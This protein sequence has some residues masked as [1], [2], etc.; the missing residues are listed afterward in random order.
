MFSF[1]AVQ[2]L[3]VLSL[4]VFTKLLTPAD[5]GVY[6][7]FNNTVRVFAIVFSLN[8]FSGYYR[9]Y[10]E[11]DISNKAL[12]QYLLRISF[13]SFLIGTFVFWYFYSTI[14]NAINLPIKLAF[15]LIISIFS[16]IVISFFTNYNNA[17]QKSKRA[18]IWQFIIQ[19]L[20]VVGSL[21]FVIY[22]SKNYEGRIIGENSMLFLITIVIAIVYF[23]KYFG[24][25][26]KLPNKNEIIRYSLNLIPIGLSGFAL[27]Y[28]DTIMI[29]KY[30]GSTDAG[31]YSYA[32]KIT[33]IYSGITASFLTANRP[34]LYELMNDNKND[35]VIIQMRSMFKV[36]IALA[37]FFIF[38]AKDAGQLLA[39]NVEFH[40]GLYL[41]PVLILSYILND[42]NDLYS[43]YISYAKKINY[44]YLS[45]FIA[46]I[47]NFLLNLY[48]I[49]KYGYTVAAY[50]TLISFASMLICTYI[51]CKIILK[52]KIPAL[53]R[54]LD[55]LCIIAIVFI[56]NY[57]ATEN[58]ANWF[59]Q[60]TIKGCTYLLVLLYLWRNIIQRFL[61][62]E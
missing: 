24:W 59:L 27:G 17:Q 6:E 22:F 20:R 19:V 11:K 61:S 26:E 1:V 39:L 31:L 48:F 13:F 2:A 37:C 21:L 38:F 50:T 29:N 41:L 3:M 8:L 52:L 54:F 28:L 36:I 55:Y 57:F 4:P 33:T 7:V 56:V 58:I 5:F 42:L 12:M 49:P 34:K 25:S 32:Y 15:W 53:V 46:A 60:I 40:Y 43:F 10:F 9:F 45:F 44:F 18:G 14:L 51:I 30:N 16:N 62:K 35:D 23:R 47:I